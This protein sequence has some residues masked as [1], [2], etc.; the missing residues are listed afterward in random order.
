MSSFEGPASEYP[1]KRDAWLV[2]VLWIAS[3]VMLFA[4]FEVWGSAEPF[5]FRLAYAVGMVAL[6]LFVVWLLYS[7]GYTLTDR[8]LL[9]R[10]GPFRWR[11]PL[12]A[13]EEVR[14]TRNPLSA[15][16]CSLD[17]LQIRYEGRRL[18][19]LI[20]PVYRFRVTNIPLHPGAEVFPTIEVVNRLYPP[21]GRA[22]EFPVISDSSALPS[23][24]FPLGGEQYTSA[25]H[26]CV[27]S[28][29]LM[30]VESASG[31]FVAR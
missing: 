7:T 5:P 15:P 3:A 14:P 26:C 22:W 23:P 1:S 17:R 4:A 8:D 28:N 24:S 16:A 11:V 18:G 10:A 25:A 9:A 30:A 6:A 19:L 13:I 12:A 2:A 29:N 20:S 27:N 31:F 21:E